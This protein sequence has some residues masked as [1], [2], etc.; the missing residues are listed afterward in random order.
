[1]KT[2]TVDFYGTGVV[3]GKRQ[4][5]STSATPRTVSVRYEEGV[6]IITDHLGIEFH[7]PLTTIKEITV[8]N[9]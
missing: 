9:E 6:A 7:Y 8:K 4:F 1:M 5:S 2:I 3:Y